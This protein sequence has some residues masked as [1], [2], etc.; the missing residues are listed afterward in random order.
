MTIKFLE[1]KAIVDSYDSTLFDTLEI[2]FGKAKEELAILELNNSKLVKEKQESTLLI[3]FLNDEL[4]SLNEKVVSFESNV[5]RLENKVSSL[6][7]GKACESS[8]ASV[9]PSCELSLLNEKLKFIEIENLKLKEVI[10]KFTRSQASLNEIICGVGSNSNKHGLG[11]KSKPRRSN[12]RVRFVP[13]PASF[14]NYGQNESLKTSKV[15]CHYCCQKGHISVDC[16]ARMYPYKCI[17]KPKQQ[18]N[19]VGTAS[20]LPNDAFL[21]GASSSSSA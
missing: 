19:I 20:R 4:S 5:V 3:S 12:K 21:V 18:T 6:E 16:F 14:Y 9:S 8:I 7:K 10:S 17:W 2:E 15:Q 13:N 11:Y 1:M